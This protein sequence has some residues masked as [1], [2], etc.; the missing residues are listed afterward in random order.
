MFRDSWGRKKYDIL[1]VCRGSFQCTRTKSTHLVSSS[2]SFPVFQER[3]KREI[4]RVE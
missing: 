1:D 2:P 4:C 3:I